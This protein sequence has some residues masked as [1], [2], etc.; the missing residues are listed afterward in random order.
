MNHPPILQAETFRTHDSVFLAMST[1]Q[2]GVS[3]EPYGMNLSFRVGDTEENVKRNREL[4]FGR[5]GIGIDELAIPQQV[6]SA[7]VQAVD[8]PGM[9][10]QCDA[11]VSNRHRVFLCVSVADCVPIFLFEKSQSVVAAIHAGWRGTLQR[12]V[13]RTVELMVHQYACNPSDMIAYIGP[14]ARS[15]CYEVGKEVA[16]R[17]AVDYIRKTRDKFF[18]DLKDANLNQLIQSGVPVSSIEIS[19]FCT[20][21]EPALFH[22]YRRDGQKSG[23]MLGVIGLL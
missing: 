18:L 8:R 9:Y 7:V 2:G 16:D 11:L 15:C 13:E 17:F 1:R 19:E 21:C 5:L 3:P 23:R 22:S 6:H 10:G 4:F 20:I 12:I 14:S